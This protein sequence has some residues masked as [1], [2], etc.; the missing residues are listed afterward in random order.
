MGVVERDR[1]QRRRFADKHQEG[2]SLGEWHIWKTRLLS[3]IEQPGVDQGHGRKGAIDKTVEHA[4]ALALCEK[5]NQELTR[6]YSLLSGR[7]RGTLAS[8]VSCGSLSISLSYSEKPELQKSTNSLKRSKEQ[9]PRLFERRG[10]PAA[11]SSILY[12]RLR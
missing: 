4:R 10:D 1:R 12:Y 3:A 7:L 8:A 6:S 9:A 2:F 11:F 5:D